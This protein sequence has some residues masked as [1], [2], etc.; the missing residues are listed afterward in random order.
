VKWKAYGQSKLANYHF[1]LGLQQRF[2]AAGVSASSLLAH[3][4]LSDTDLQSSSVK[5]TEGGFVQRF[6]HG[7]ASSTGMTPAQGALPQLRAATGPRATAA[8]S[9]RRAS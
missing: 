6:F 7:L 2:E 8:S 1:A 5:E 3:P 9:M 4:G